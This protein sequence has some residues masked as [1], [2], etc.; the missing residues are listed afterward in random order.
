MKKD[1]NT[2]VGLR[3]EEPVLISRFTEPEYPLATDADLFVSA[4]GSDENDGSF[5]RPLRTFNK[6]VE[7]VREL[8]KTKSGDI[9]VA[10]RA[11]EYG[12][13]SVELTPRDSG[14]ETGRITYCGYGD[15]PVVFSGGLDLLPEDFSDLDEGD[16]ALFPPDA[17]PKIKKTDISSFLYSNGA[18]HLIIFGDGGDLTLARY[19]DKNPD[20]TDAFVCQAGYTPDS[21]HIRINSP[22]LMKRIEKYRAPEKIM[23]YGYLTTGWYRDLL[24]TAGYETDP[25]TGSFDFLIPHPEKARMGHLRFRELDGFDSEFWNKTVVVNAPEELDAKGEYWIDT[26]TGTL[27]LYDPSGEYHITGGSDMIRSHGAK[28][29]TFRGFDFRLSGGFMIRADGHPRGMTVDGCR[30]FGCSAKLMV[31]IE[32]GDTGVPLDVSV[33]NCEFSNSASTALYVGAMDEDDLFGTCSNVLIDNNLFT[34]TNLRDGNNGAVKIFAPFSR[35]SHNEFRRCCWEGVDFRKAVNMTA[36]YNVFDRVCFNGDDTGALNNYSSVDRCGNV[37]RYNLFVNIRGGTNGRYCL[38]LDDST[39]TETC[40]NLFYRTDFTSMNNGISKYNVFRDNILINPEDDEPTGCYP[41]TDAT[42]AVEKAMAEGDPSAITSH[43]YYVRWKDAFAYFDAHPDA[44]A[45]AA[46]L[47]DGF[48][49]V[50]LDLEDWQKPEFCMNSSLVITNNPEINRAG[51]A[52]EYDE[53]ISKYSVIRGNVGYKVTENPFF[54]DPTRGD[55]RIREGV[56]FP[57]IHFELMGRY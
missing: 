43:E 2:S 56:D 21:V 57:D 28:Y 53:T 27:Y 50:S 40:S 15:G 55:Y 46:E 17:V 38:Y 29:L 45:K 20:G 54:V 8:K 23:L 16:A 5:E 42:L 22:E 4:S 44:K 36:E 3:Y 10:F 24:E 1:L 12:P 26:E 30:F 11:G 39:G 31:S 52:R 32:G 33:K 9:T 6:A 14:G 13:L 48:F 19:P 18:D 7:A 34:L 37:V 49:D 25:E 41:K 47:W 35:I 51:V